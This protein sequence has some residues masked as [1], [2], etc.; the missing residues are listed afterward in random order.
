MTSPTNREMRPVRLSELIAGLS[1]VTDLGMG[2]PMEQAMITCLLS[3]KAGEALNLDD[4]TLSEVYYL[5]LLRFI[6][7]TADASEFAAATGGDDLA[8]RGGLAPVLNGDVGEILGHLV[9]H[10][11]EGSPPLTRARLL[12]A[13]LA[14]GTKN[15]KRSIADHC[16]V[17]QMLAPRI[18]ISPAVARYVGST[19][20]YWNGKGIPGELAGEDIPLSCR[21]VSVARDVEVLSRMD[22]WSFT[23]ACLTRRRGKAYDPTV[24]DLFLSSGQGWLDQIGKQPVWEAVIDAEPGIPNHLADP[25][26]DEV[27]GAI[28]D[29]SDLKAPYAAGHSRTVAEISEAAGRIL[30]LDE[31]Q[32]KDLRRAA[33]LHDV[34]KVGVPSGILDH[35]GPLTRTEEERVRLHPYYTERVLSYVPAL[36]DVSAL[37]GAHHERLD[38]SGYHRGS[39]GVELQTPA[40]VLAAANAYQALCQPRPYRPALDEAAREHEMKR[41]ADEGKLDARAVA[42]VLEASGH[43]A[44]IRWKEWPAGLTDREVEV[45]RLIAQGHSSR[46]V[47]EELTISIKTVGRHIENIYGKTSAS[48]RATA[49]LFAMQHDL[50]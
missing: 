12:A 45:L 2:Q 29:L 27:L 15:A 35:P 9:R 48:S 43:A 37:A 21:I 7:C 18:G 10:L 17:A 11:A 47:A 30:N 4:A 23:A 49:A 14:T 22:S 28:A 26:I 41:Q 25:Q 36:G 16:E 31:R 8:Q 19:F 33:F 39:S 46:S 5:A 13:E 40:R 44:R 34:G 1:L 38:G 32:I 20:E 24:T 3:V 42:A 50:I 6:G